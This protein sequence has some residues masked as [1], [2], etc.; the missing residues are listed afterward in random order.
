MAGA[1]LQS[2]A[3]F[4]VLMT[5]E[6]LV[7]PLDPTGSAHT[8]RP[9]SSIFTFTWTSA[10]EVNVARIS[11]GSVGV[12]SRI[13]CGATNEGLA[14]NCPCSLERASD[15]CET[16]VLPPDALRCGGGPGRAA[17]SPCESAS[18]S[19]TAEVFGGVLGICGGKTTSRGLICALKGAGRATDFRSRVEELTDWFRTASFAL[20]AASVRTVS[21][22]FLLSRAVTSSRN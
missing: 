4:C 5:R 15:G 2:R 7:G 13:G 10:S 3:A 11:G 20:G 9:S 17:R 14:A 6:L 19:S 8:T 16:F 1:N 12:D 18:C 22:V 21:L